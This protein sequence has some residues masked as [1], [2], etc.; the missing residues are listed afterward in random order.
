MRASQLH[1]G[2]SKWEKIKKDKTWKE[3]PLQLLLPL[4]GIQTGLSQ[5]HVPLTE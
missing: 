1:K 3:M 4:S 5:P 2:S